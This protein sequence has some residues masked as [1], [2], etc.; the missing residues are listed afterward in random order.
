MLL[1][2]ALFF[3]AFSFPLVAAVPCLTWSPLWKFGQLHT[4]PTLIALWSRA[5]HPCCSEELMRPSVPGYNSTC[6]PSSGELVALWKLFQDT[7]L[8]PAPSEASSETDHN[9]GTCMAGSAVKE[10]ARGKAG[11]KCPAKS[12][13]EAYFFH[14]LVRGYNSYA[15]GKIW[16]IHLWGATS[17]CMVEILWEYMGSLQKLYSSFLSRRSNISFWPYRSTLCG[18]EGVALLIYADWKLSPRRNVQ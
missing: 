5:E 18:F 11:S 7:E 12:C 14:K 13:E 15:N 6:L 9:F 16:V 2:T 4:T 1:P 3:S 10:D 8:N 17:S